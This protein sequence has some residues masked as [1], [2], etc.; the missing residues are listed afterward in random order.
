ME[1]KRKL[2]IYDE[3]TNRKVASSSGS[4]VRTV[5]DDVLAKNPK[6]AHF[7]LYLSCDARQLALIP[8]NGVEQEF[9]KTE[10]RECFNEEMSAELSRSDFD[11]YQHCGT[12]LPEEQRAQVLAAIDIIILRLAEEHGTRIEVLAEVQKRINEWDL[13]GDKGAD[14]H[15]QLGKQYARR[16][17]LNAGKGKAPLFW[18]ARNKSKIVQEFKAL[19]VAVGN[20]LDGGSDARALSDTVDDLLDAAPEA[21]PTL[22]RAGVNL[23][24]FLQSRSADAQSFFVACDLTPALLADELMAWSTNRE[25]ESARQAA[26]RI[27]SKRKT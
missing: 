19:R 13:G 18:W 9:L 24:V 26:S 21:Y 25:P 6:V 3:G 20:R 12:E 14:L 22:I 11:K 15:E 23:Q 2:E 8:E 17:R 1:T 4:D 27:L 16:T 10:M 5:L 7:T